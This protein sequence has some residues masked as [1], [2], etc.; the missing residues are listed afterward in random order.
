ME[1]QSLINFVVDRVHTI[2][3]L[4]DNEFHL[5]ANSHVALGARDL[6]YDTLKEIEEVHPYIAEQ[7]DEHILRSLERAQDLFIKR[8]YI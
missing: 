2:N 3:Y 8:L 6:I 5:D 1:T 4:I 7:I